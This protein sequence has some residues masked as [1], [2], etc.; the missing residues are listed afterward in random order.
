ML[1]FDSKSRLFKINICIFLKEFVTY[2]LEICV[3]QVST[4]SKNK[5]I[6]VFWLFDAIN[7][8]VC[9]RCSTHRNHAIIV[10]QKLYAFPTT[11]I[12]CVQSEFQIPNRVYYYSKKTETMSF[13]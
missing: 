6:A 8:N 13:N 12:F 3:K 1:K 7:N 10:I 11:A 5:L 2:K 4:W 9:L